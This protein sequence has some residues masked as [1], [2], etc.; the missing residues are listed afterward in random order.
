MSLYRWVVPPV[1]VT[2][3]VGFIFTPDNRH[4]SDSLTASSATITETYRVDA[5]RL[6]DAA[7]TDGTAYQRIGYIADVFGPRFSGTQSLEASID[8]VM[9]EMR[10]DGFD[11]VKSEPV[12]VPHWVRGKESAELVEPRRQPLNM[13]GLGSSI[14][15]PAEGVTAPV[16]VV[17]SFDELTRRSAEAKGKIVLFNVPFAGYRETVPYRIQGAVAAARAGAVAM[18]VRSVASASMQSPHT[19]NMRYD[20]TVTRIPAAAVSVEDA[21][22][23]RR[24]VDRGE[25]PVVTLRMGAQI[26]PDVMSRNI[27]AQING[28]EKPDEIVLLGG[29]IDSWDVGRGAMD[30]AGGAVAAWEAVRLIKKLGLHPKRTIRV[31]LWTNEENGARGAAAYRDAHAAELSKHVLAIESDNGTFAPLGFRVTGSEFVL[32]AG[33]GV[34]TLLARINAGTVEREREGPETD[35]AP[36]VEKGVPGMGL[37]VDRTKYFWYHH[38]AADTF[39]KLD[40]REVAS[41][42][43]AMAVMAYV[44][45]DR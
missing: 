26:L 8:W 15:T 33:Q 40:A 10:R 21:L 12:M 5:D 2:A 34:G 29:H 23:L 27:I 20:S 19:G 25:R 16:L 14:G 41:C 1:V 3:V 7:L 11:I 45:G 42:I 44:F 35:I 30:D 4:A 22:L 18:L 31:V 6:I 28:N 17:S 36:L 39:D 9:S 13:I 38:S 32:N 37:T 24:L 43:G